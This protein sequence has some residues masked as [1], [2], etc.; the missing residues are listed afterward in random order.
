MKEEIDTESKGRKERKVEGKK[1]EPKD[2]KD[3]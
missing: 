2:K 3:R 1:E